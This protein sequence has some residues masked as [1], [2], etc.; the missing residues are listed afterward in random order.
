MLNRVL[1]YVKGVMHYGLY[2]RKSVSSTIHVFVNLNWVGNPNDR[3]STSGFVVFFGNNLVSYACRKQR[4][5]ARSSTK[6]K[7]KSLAYVSAEITWLISPLKDLHVSF[8]QP[9]KLV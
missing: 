4:T 7:Y 9:P 8:E 5:V 6:A 1:I 2:P 3:K